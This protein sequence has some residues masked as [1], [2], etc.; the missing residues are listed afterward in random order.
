MVRNAVAALFACGGAVAFGQ[1]P[2]FFQQYLQRL[3]GALDQVRQRGA[4]IIADAAA[5]GLSVES[6]IAGFL[7]SPSHALEGLRMQDS[8][9]KLSQMERT[10]ELLSTAPAWQRS[11]LFLRYSDQALAE[12]TL[13]AFQPAL[14]ITIEGLG[15]ALTGG[16][17]ALLLYGA[18]RKTWRWSSAH[19]HH[20]KQQE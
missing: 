5:K 11:G 7:A 17:L 8:L 15:Y 4:E 13:R 20:G 12:E 1:F 18:G 2:E 16:F 19:K 9:L 14:P 6:Y 10:H 3:G